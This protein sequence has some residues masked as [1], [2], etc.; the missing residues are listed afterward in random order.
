MIINNVEQIANPLLFFQ[1]PHDFVG[2]PV[3]LKLEG[4][5]IAGSIKLKTAIGLIDGLQRDNKIIRGKTKIIESSSGNLGV[6]LSIVCKS[7]NIPFVCV[8]DLN[9]NPNNVQLMQLYEAQVICVTQRDENGGYLGTRIRTI[10]Q[11]LADDPYLVWTNQYEN[12]N[13]PMTHYLTTAQ[14]IKQEFP[15]VDYLFIGAG[16]TGTV[17]G[18]GKYFQEVSPTTKV[19]GVDVE[20]SVTF[21]YE[22]KK[23]NIPGLGTSKRPP[24]VDKSLV[25]EVLIIGEKDTVKMCNQILNLYGLLVGGST[26]TVLSAIH[27]QK[28]KFKPGDIVVAISPDFGERYLNTIYDKTWVAERIA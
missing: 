15:K 11:M 2:V 28:S 9:A 24:I 6:A 17:M 10:N 8:T 12:L 18:C 7:R 22:A 1:L 19:I 26:G 21:C 23:R 3:Y 25:N 20:G 16:T 13:N 4:F 14:E 27:K 5:N